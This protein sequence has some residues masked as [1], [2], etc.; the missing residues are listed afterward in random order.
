MTSVILCQFTALRL[1]DKIISDTCLQLCICGKEIPWSAWAYAHADQY[2]CYPICYHDLVVWSSC[3]RW[4]AN[5]LDVGN[6]DTDQTVHPHSLMPVWI[7]SAHGVRPLSA[8][9]WIVI[10]ISLCWR[11]DHGPLLDVKQ[12]LR[13]YAPTRLWPDCPQ[14]Q[15]ANC[16]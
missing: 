1:R 4:H 11:A 6:K 10:Q 16:W 2:I 15:I 13:T 7:Q 14:N 12:E 8:R 3:E 9:Q 5:C